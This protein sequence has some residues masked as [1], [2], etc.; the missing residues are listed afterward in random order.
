MMHVSWRKRE[1]ERERERERLPHG[2]VCVFGLRG[3]CWCSRL[4]CWCIEWQQQTSCESSPG[5]K[6]LSEHLR[7]SER[8][9]GTHCTHTHTQ[10]QFTCALIAATDSCRWP[11]RQPTLLLQKHH[12]SLWSNFAFFLHLIALALNFVFWQHCVYGLIRF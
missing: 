5:W 9:E 8:W 7:G 6:G 12:I 1:R 11:S 4:V 10:T 2:N 3:N